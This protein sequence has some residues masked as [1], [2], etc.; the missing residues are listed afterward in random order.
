MSKSSIIKNS[1]IIMFLTIISKITGFFRDILVA[2]EYG[3][4]YETDAYNIALTIPTLAFTLIGTA[5]STI[6]IPIFT[7]ILMRQGKEKMYVFAN[8]ILLILF[9]II[10]II[11]VLLFLQTNNIVE[12]LAP[13][14]DDATKILTIKLAKICMINLI[15]LAIYSVFSAILQSLNEFTSVAMVGIV[16]NIPIII[17]VLIFNKYGIFGLTAIN[18]LGY[19]LQV[20]IQIPCLLK[21][22]YKFT[23]SF[24]FKDKIFK[25]IPKLLIPVIIGVGINQVN[26]LVDQV[27]A[28]GLEE[29]TISAI[30]LSNKVNMIIY[31]IYAA[32][33]MTALYPVLT[34][35]VEK[36]NCFKEHISKGICSIT[37]IMLP[38]SV[39]IMILSRQLVVILFQRGIFD[40]KS[41]EMTSLATLFL[42]IGTIFYSVRDIIS[43]AFYSLRNT[44]TPMKNCIVGV[45]VNVILD[46]SLSKTM[47]IA[48]LA[49]ATSISAITMAVLLYISLRKKI[50]VILEKNFI[51]DL[52]KI[53]I[54]T[55]IMGIC[56]YV[57]RGFIVY[58]SGIHLLMDLIVV[59]CIAAILYFTMLKVLK[60]SI[61]EEQVSIVKNKMKKFFAKVKSNRKIKDI[62]TCEDRNK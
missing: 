33:I 57:M 31:G 24:D 19:A 6:F 12:V 53:M 56:V 10:L 9:G 41:V 43:K 37:L 47:G 34:S 52:L 61:F 45:C 27:V 7:R 44:T 22:K 18:I 38:A 28:S 39:G 59:I 29:G 20:L 15:F 36:I 3:T 23:I 50:G 40:E 51:Y 58:K 11:Y 1:A 26:V 14:F 55:V 35:E 16:I 5:V 32:S 49:L 2:S 25:D 30:N 62:Y 60:T 17:Y 21:N 8:K 4:T 54:S 13:K 46:I 42:A 48:G